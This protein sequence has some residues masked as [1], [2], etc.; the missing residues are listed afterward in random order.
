LA[1]SGAQYEAR[2]SGRVIT[3]DRATTLLA[4]S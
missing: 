2:K 4:G 1:P 3:N